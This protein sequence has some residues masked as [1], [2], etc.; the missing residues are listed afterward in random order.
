MNGRRLIVFCFILLFGISPAESQTVEPVPATPSNGFG[1]TDEYYA[2][3]DPPHGGVVFHSGKY[4]VEFIVDPFAGEEKV[5]VY[6]LNEKYKVK[7]PNKI[8][9]IAT[10]KYGDGKTTEKM[11]IRKE[12][13]FY[14]DLDDII[15]PCNIVLLIKVRKK[16]YKAAYFYKGLTNK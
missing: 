10:L 5:T 15:N 2:S 8:S 4:D 14:C 3:M 12:E 1:A 16:K 13:W 11:M 7:K 6:L 9:I